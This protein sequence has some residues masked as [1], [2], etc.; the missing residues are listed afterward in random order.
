MEVSKKDQSKRTSAHPP[1]IVL[2]PIVNWGLNITFASL[3]SLSVFLLKFLLVYVHS[4]Y[5]KGHSF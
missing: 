1:I 5:Y 4:K 2:G 3:M